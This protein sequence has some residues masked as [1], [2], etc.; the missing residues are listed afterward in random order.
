MPEGD[1]SGYPAVSTSGSKHSGNPGRGCSSIG[2]A[3]ALQAGGRRFDPVQ[4]H[5]RPGKQQTSLYLS[6]AVS[7]HQ[8]SGVDI[9]EGPNQDPECRQLKAVLLFNNLEGKA[10]TDLMRVRVR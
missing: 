7:R 2:R 1:L 10:Y 9:R 6:V 3:P 5:Q 8:V 4:L